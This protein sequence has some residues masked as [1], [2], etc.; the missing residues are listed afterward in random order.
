MDIFHGNRSTPTSSSWTVSFGLFARCNG[1]FCVALATCRHRSRGAHSFCSQW[2]W[3]RYFR[4][5]KPCTARYPHCLDRENV[6]LVDTRV[7]FVGGLGLQAVSRQE[8]G[9]LIALFCGSHILFLLLY[10]T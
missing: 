10:P 6:D 4:L 5:A 3:Y 9:S 1:E 2:C 7:V 8:T